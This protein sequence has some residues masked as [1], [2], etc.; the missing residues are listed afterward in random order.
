MNISTKLFLGPCHE[1]DLAKIQLHR[2]NAFRVNVEQIDKQTD[3]F[4]KL[5]QLKLRIAF[6]RVSYLNL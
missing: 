2:G 4:G 6:E 5:T 3:K 1:K